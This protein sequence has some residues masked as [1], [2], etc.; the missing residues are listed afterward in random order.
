LSFSSHKTR[1]GKSLGTRGLGAFL[2]YEHLA[3][4]RTDIEWA[5]IAACRRANGE[6]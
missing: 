1:G 2:D 6:P 5:E 3:V 4:V